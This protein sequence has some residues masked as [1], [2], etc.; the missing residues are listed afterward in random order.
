MLGGPLIRC[1]QKVPGSRPQRPSR[2]PTWTAR[3]LA[4]SGSCRPVALPRG[5]L[6]RGLGQDAGCGS[7][8][9][10]S[11]ALP[12]L[13]FTAFLHRAPQLPPTR[14]LGAR[15][16]APSSQSRPPLSPAAGGGARGLSVR[17]PSALSFGLQGCG[18]DGGGGWGAA[19]RTLGSCGP[20]RWGH[21]V[22]TAVGQGSA[23]TAWLCAKWLQPKSAR[24][25]PSAPLSPPEPGL[26]PGKACPALTCPPTPSEGQVPGTEGG[27]SRAPS[28]RGCSAVRVDG[29]IDVCGNRSCPEVESRHPVLGPSAELFGVST[30]W[31]Q[32]RPA[33]SSC[34]CPLAGVAAALWPCIARLRP[35]KVQGVKSPPTGYLAG[36]G[37][38]LED[39]LQL[40]LAAG[41]P[42]GLYKRAGGG[43]VQAS[44]VRP[45]VW[46]SH[47]PQ[48]RSPGLTRKTRV[49][50]PW[51]PPS[52]RPR[53]RCGLGSR[54]QQTRG[55]RRVCIRGRCGQA[56]P[57][58]AGGG[59][60]AGVQRR[61]GQGQG[62][63]GVLGG[64]GGQGG[65]G[66]CTRDEALMVTGPQDHGEGSR[67]SRGKRAR[68]E[69]EQRGPERDAPG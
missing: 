30:V 35:Q 61:H 51:E 41:P 56:P 38:A 65:S 69:G 62:G 32:P 9:S 5:P 2:L 44:P 10:W 22:V 6:R 11:I 43:G 45:P 49:S 19:S 26:F 33:L 4:L 47:R 23:C 31:P 50:S 37:G 60:G 8:A 20:G 1:L 24:T 67:T 64:H 63:R 25:W 29:S 14:V 21:N 34:G 46:S 57:H 59:R 42:L 17:S 15:A 3:C 58:T 12:T 7:L 55:A 48:P 13:S 53:A 54:C 28:H 52:Q 39:Q 68:D 16:G 36:R 40:L 18:V 66:E 27:Q